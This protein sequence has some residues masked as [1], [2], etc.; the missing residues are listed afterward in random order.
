[1]VFVKVVSGGT[2]GGNV[3]HDTYLKIGAGIENVE[4]KRKL[5]R[6]NVFFVSVFKKV[7]TVYL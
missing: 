5:E 4:S 1:M 6:L 2:V 7:L 3:S